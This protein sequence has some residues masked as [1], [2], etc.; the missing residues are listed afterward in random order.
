[1]RKGDLPVIVRLVLAHLSHVHH[2][3]VRVNMKASGIWVSRENL[4]IGVLLET[5]LWFSTGNRLG[6]IFN[7]FEIFENLNI[8][9]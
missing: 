2:C 7:L 5:P 9:T 1:M 3:S 4:F 6:W 8:M